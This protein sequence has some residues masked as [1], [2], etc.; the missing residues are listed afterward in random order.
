MFHS[1]KPINCIEEDLLERSNVAR[2]FSKHILNYKNNNSLTIGI[3][4]KW[5]S[6]KTSFINMVLELISKNQDYIIVKFNPW[7]ISSRKQLISDFFTELSNEIGRIDSSEIAKEVGKNLKILSMFFKPLA[8]APVPQI[9]LFASIFG[10]YLEKIGVILDKYAELQKLDLDQIKE[11]LNMQLKSLGKKVIIIIDDIDRLSD[12]DIKEIFQLVRSIADFEN[13][14]YMLSYDNE[15]VSN[16]LNKLQD[17]KGEKYLEKIVQVPIFL[18]HITKYEINNLFLTRL[19][20]V[21]NITEE[22]FDRE[23]F[24]ELS[25]NGFL[26]NLENIRDIERYLNTFSFGLNI[27]KEE[28]NICDYMAITIF[29]V[30]EPELYKYIQENEENFTDVKFVREREGQKE[31]T[32]KELEE[33]FKNL[34]KISIENARNLIET[35]FPKIK[36]LYN[37]TSYDSGFILEWNKKRRI[38]SSRYFSKYFKLDFPENEIKK[39]EINKIINF[40]SKGELI[41]IF[42]VKNSKKLELLER[43]LE[44]VD[45]IKDDKKS[46]FLQVILSLTDNLEIEGKKSFFSYIDQ[47]RYKVSR[48]FFK[49]IEITS[50]EEKIKIIK[51]VFEA[52]ECSLESL[53]SILEIL[54]EDKDRYGMTEEMINELIELLIHRIIQRSEKAENIPK[55]FLEI[56]YSMKRLGRPEEAK[57]TCANYI[58]N[59]ELLLSLVESFIRISMSSKGYQEAIEKKYIMKEDIECFTNYEELVQ[60]ID[61]YI[62]NPTNEELEIIGYLKSPK[63]SSK[64]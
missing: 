21:I 60:M 19:A 40:Q 17:G 62:K 4:G 28:L 3:I 57:T 32:K 30:F 27:M 7:N 36:E 9:S 15:I 24:N 61:D 47:S 16:A 59:K 54:R 53:T 8:L 23:Y 26:N 31:K 44:I 20:K 37:N 10:K 39:S 22:E 55:Y 35:I 34:K 18:P 33:H 58:K 42:N 29:K 1:E 13:T 45:E 63:I 50:L 46:E 64:K 25:V 51:E 38:A 49:T 48:M 52:E 12:E 11:K 56:L 5:G 2:D 14:I 6:G 41:D 43:I